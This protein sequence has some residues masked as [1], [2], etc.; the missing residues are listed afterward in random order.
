MQG[1]LQD[2]GVRRP[3]AGSVPPSRRRQRTRDWDD[4]RALK[5]LRRRAWSADPDAPFEFDADFSSSFDAPDE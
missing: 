4:W 2:L 5:R 3:G 1:R